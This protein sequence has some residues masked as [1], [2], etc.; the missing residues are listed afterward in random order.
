MYQSV[1]NSIFSNP[2]D[3]ILGVFV[4][5]LGEFESI[6]ATMKE[7]PYPNITKVSFLFV[8]QNRH[9]KYVMHDYKKAGDMLRV[10]P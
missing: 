6:Y 4:M 2:F 9:S 10:D 5:S 8:I 3:A 7:T 1:P